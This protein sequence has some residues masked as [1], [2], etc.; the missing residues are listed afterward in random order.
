MKI[1][2]LFTPTAVAIYTILI[3]QFAEYL[4]N[5]NRVNSGLTSLEAFLPTPLTII[6]TIINNFNLLITELYYTLFRGLLGL[7]VGT[8]FSFLMTIVIIFFPKFR[9]TFMSIVMSLNSFPIVGFAPVI[10][11]IFGQGSVIGII[12]ISALISYFPTF[13]VLD[14]AA[15]EVNEEFINLAKIWGANKW[16]IFTKIQL[17]YIFPYLFTSLKLSLPASII[18]ATLGEW[19][20]AKNGIGRLITISLYQLRPGILYAS[21]VLIMISIKFLIKILK[22]LERLIIPWKNEVK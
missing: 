12:F 9:N 19:L 15:K 16:N 13:I 1:K 10:I 17:P 3:W 18:G 20:G 4:I 5:M 21:L 22:I 14:K 8:I 7:I 2:Y 11:L 6:T